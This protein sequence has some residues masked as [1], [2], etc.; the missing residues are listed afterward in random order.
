MH[1]IGIS[2]YDNLDFSKGEIIAYYDEDGEL[3]FENSSDVIIY[4]KSFGKTKD[5]EYLLV[6]YFSDSN[7]VQGIKKS[8]NI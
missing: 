6:D 1:E 3:T 2:E 5:N 4:R 7:L 8:K